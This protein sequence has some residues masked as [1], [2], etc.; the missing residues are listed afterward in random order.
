MADSTLTVAVNADTSGLE[1]GLRSTADMINA[2]LKTTA[3]ESDKAKTPVADL[4]K[5]MQVSS[6]RAIAGMIRGTETWQKA[7]FNIMQDLEIKFVQLNAH[8]LII[9]A[10]G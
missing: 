1:S 5:A 9:W 4:F 7:M 8:K 10:E 6:D 3:L 2:A